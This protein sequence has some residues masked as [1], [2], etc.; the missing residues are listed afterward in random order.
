[1]SSQGR[2][3]RDTN[4]KDELQLRA[5]RFD[6][7]IQE[8]RRRLKRSANAAQVE[9]ALIVACRAIG[10]ANG[11]TAQET[12]TLRLLFD[13]LPSHV[14]EA[15]SRSDA[16]SLKSLIGRA[17][18]L[19]GVS[20]SAG[21]SI[22]G[23]EELIT[24]ATLVLEGKRKQAVDRTSAIQSLQDQRLGRPWVGW[25]VNVTY[26]YL[27]I[28][29]L[30]DPIERRQRSLKQAHRE[31]EVHP[32]AGGR[33][34]EAFVPGRSAPH[35]IETR[36]WWVTWIRRLTK[37]FANLACP[38][39][40]AWNPTRFEGAGRFCSS[41]EWVWCQR[42]HGIPSPVSHRWVNCEGRVWPAPLMMEPTRNKEISEI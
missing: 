8:A 15:I 36:R 11:L 42:C 4:R 1:M 28:M 30:P 6:A 18:A 34:G 29:R 32:C 7:S 38:F 19:A 39:C 41:C 16:T 25:C 22:D 5:E 31:F 12:H 40:G 27:V 24:A 9:G 26:P 14:I 37:F 20:K 33:T 2:P 10:G 23:L 13:G 21:G 35:G 3:D 17:R